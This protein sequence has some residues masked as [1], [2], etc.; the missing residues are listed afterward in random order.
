MAEP[1]PNQIT[2][3]NLGLNGDKEFVVACKGRPFSILTTPL[4]PVPTVTYLDYNLVRDLN[5]RMSSLQCRKLFYGGE[6]LRILGQISTTVQCIINGSPLGNIQ[7]K[8]HVVE[9]LKKYF[10][11]H[12]IAGE[13]LSKKLLGQHAD[14][15]PA[16][17]SA[18][19]SDEESDDEKPKKKRKKSKKTDDAPHPPKAPT[20]KPKAASPDK[21]V[22]TSPPRPRCQGIWIKTQSYN[23]WHPEHGYG[24]PPG[25]LRDCYQDRRS[26]LAQRERPECWDSEGPF[27]SEDS[28]SSIYESSDEYDDEYTNVSH[29]RQNTDTNIGSI[30]ANDVPVNQA[31]TAHPPPFLTVDEAREA[32]AANAVAVTNSS[33]VS[34][35]TIVKMMTQ[36][37]RK[38]GM[39]RAHTIHALQCAGINT[40][41]KTETVKK[42]MIS[43][44]KPFTKEDLRY[45]TTLRREGKDVPSSLKHVPS[46]HGPDWCHAD[47]VKRKPVHHKCGFHESWGSVTACSPLCNGGYCDHYDDPGNYEKQDG[48]S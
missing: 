41:Q 21:A 27:H 6:K 9:D 14:V 36:N 25:V 31:M 43:N 37:C 32:F 48:M 35:N 45:V 12:G 1:K 15:F 10:N 2:A 4:L 33:P 40:D 24:G 23:G 47:C 29:I 11:T 18:E 30:N 5:L 46:L 22:L 7:M 44:G 39:D 26:G 42:A 28:A 17:A 8:C 20:P 3:C 16:K 38:A 19:P 34:P 13:K